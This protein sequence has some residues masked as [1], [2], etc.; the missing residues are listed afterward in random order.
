MLLAEPGKSHYD[1]SFNIFGFPVRVH[2][3]FFILPVV[4]GASGAGQAENPGA[5]ILIYIIVLF[6]SIL[7]HELG[8]AIAFRYYRIPSR[9]VLYWMGG[10]AIPESSVWGGKSRLTPYQQIVVSLAG[11][12]AGFILAALTVGVVLA[13]N[14]KLVFMWGGMFPLLIPNMLGTAVEGNQSVFILLYSSLFFNLIWGAFNLMPVL[15]LDGGQVSR[16]LCTL[17]SPHNGL[18]I[19]LMISVGVGGVLAF[20]GFVNK[21]HFVGILFAILAIQS[22]QTLQQMN[23]RGG[24]RW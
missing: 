19:A 5:M 2:P 14:G 18:K 15:P 8:H 16:E 24:G 17:H 23:Y 21:D 7:V 13:L 22:W 4:L 1:F 10:L 11:P 3:G 9:I 20:L 6:V 12:F